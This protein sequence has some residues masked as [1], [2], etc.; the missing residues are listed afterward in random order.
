M[1]NMISRPRDSLVAMKVDLEY[2]FSQTNF[3]IIRTQ[4]GIDEK[5]VEECLTR[6]RNSKPMSYPFPN[7]SI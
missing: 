2:L 1:M 4:D 7:G 3:N 6:L 5:K